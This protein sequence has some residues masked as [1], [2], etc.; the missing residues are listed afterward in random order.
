[1][2]KGTSKNLLVDPQVGRS[3]LKSACV[4]VY[5]WVGGKHVGVDL[6]WVSLLI[7]LETRVLTVGHATLKAASKVVQHEKTCSNN[8]HDFIP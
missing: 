4:L 2:K 5:M 7:G 3:T 6:T 1:M 8:Q